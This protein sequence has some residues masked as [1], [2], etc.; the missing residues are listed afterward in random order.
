MS[1][2]DMQD[3]TPSQLRKRRRPSSS[4]PTSS[5]IDAGLLIEDTG[6]QDMESHPVAIEGS[7]VNQKST[8]SG[9]IKPCCSQYH[10][11]ELEMVEE[12]PAKISSKLDACIGQRGKEALKEHLEAQ[13]S[14]GLSN[15]ENVT[16]RGCLDNTYPDA[17]VDDAFK[18]QVEFW[19]K[20]AQR[21]SEASR[22]S[23]EELQPLQAKAAAAEQAV[24]AVKMESRDEELNTPLHEA[25]KE[26]RL[27]MAKGLVAI[28]ANLEEN[29][30]VGDTPLILAVTNS[31]ADVVQHLISQGADKEVKDK[32]ECNALLCAAKGG[33]LELV[34]YLVEDQ[35]MSL[36][37][38][39]KYGSNALLFA[40]AAGDNNLELVKYLVEIKGM[41]LEAKDKLYERNALHRAALGG[42]LELVKYLV[43][44]KG[45]SVEVKD[46]DG[47]NALLFAAAAGDKNLEL[48]KYL[49]EDRG[50]SL[51][52]KD[53]WK[54][55]SLLNAAQGGH[56]ELVKYLV[57]SKRMS[58]DA[59]DKWKA[60]SL[61]KA[62]QGGHLELVKYLV[63]DKGMSLEAKDEDG[64]TALHCA[65]KEDHL[66]VVKY[67]VE[68]KKTDVNTLD[69]D[70]RT[71]LHCAAEEDHLEVVKYLVED[72]KMGVNTL[73]Q[74]EHNMLHWAAKKGELELVKYLVEEQ[75]MD[76][77]AKD[78]DGRTALHFA[79]EKDHLE[80][81]KYLVEDKKMDVNTLDQ[82]G[83]TPLDLARREVEEYL[84][85]V[86]G[87]QRGG[88][89]LQ[90]WTLMRGPVSIGPHQPPQVVAAFQD[91]Q[92]EAH[93]VIPCGPGQ[94]PRYWKGFEGGP[95][96]DGSSGGGRVVEPSVLAGLFTPPLDILFP[97]QLYED[98]IR[99]ARR[100]D[101]WLLLNVQ[102]E[103]EFA[104]HQLNRD[105]WSNEAV[106][107]M[108][109]PACVFWQVIKEEPEGAKVCSLYHLTDL[110]V[111]M[112]LDPFTGC[113]LEH[114][115]GAFDA[116]QLLDTLVDY[117]EDP[118]SRS[119]KGR[120]SN[121]RLS[122]AGAPPP[123][124]EGTTQP[125][126]TSSEGA[127]PPLS[128]AR[129]EEE[130][131]ELAIAASLGLL[132]AGFSFP[133]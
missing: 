88:G 25:S 15:L 126:L 97:G 42:H 114:L 116:S 20:Q 60:N 41:S 98:A 45:M 37:A 74:N 129:D 11:Q 63:E 89:R 128:W 115:Q 109:A 2:Y 123:M 121:A 52:A 133:N 53:K 75:G 59:K 69:Q 17:R 38:K 12:R 105:V 23:A 35:G 87:A 71:A 54:A 117:F 106:K 56:L 29:N 61:L 122:S 86:P 49:V 127:G 132:E 110:P 5:D 58:L 101:K 67:L 76:L 8:S 66:E 125:S 13:A 111:V 118:P 91:F 131:L 6:G 1:A 62:A 51:E 94:G 80:V 48:V 102:T 113:K 57:E 77:E 16:A 34:K 112:I 31:H 46:K 70:G 44:D 30:K 95:V 108:V 130:A 3:G 104:S 92:Q 103:S 72:K 4:F 32:M 50:M 9:E 33:K 36:E 55:N 39:D 120:G 7:G 22:A 90:R 93:V 43:E 78:S 65:A 81:V 99:V 26:G 47:M 82:K 79:A 27:D 18:S 96:A 64:R 68:D 83:K 119:R 85:Q 40:A 107:S 21:N 84:K 73:D 14:Q 124:A 28:G 19:T 10:A 24:E 100:Q